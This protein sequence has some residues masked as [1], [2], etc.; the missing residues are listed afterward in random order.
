M[1]RGFYL[2]PAVELARLLLGQVLVHNRRAGRITEVEAY[3]GEHDL[4]AHVSRGRTARTEVIYG[5]PGHAYIYFI[6]GMHD[7]LNV[8]AEAEGSPGCVLVRAL[9]P[10]CGLE[11]MRRDCPAIPKPHL[12][13]CGPGR[14]TRAMGISR[15]HYGVD[16]TAGPIVLRQGLEVE[17]ADIVITPRIGIR[18]CADWPLRFH[19]R[20]NPSV[21]RA[22]A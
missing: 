9:E 5:P 7:C 18:L 6:Y 17:A 14:L 1:P 15:K 21:S 19:I 16:L 4:A 2:R 3:L 22:P 12:L 10:L 13:C 20:D 8:V 11:R